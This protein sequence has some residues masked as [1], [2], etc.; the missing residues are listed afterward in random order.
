MVNELTTLRESML[1]CSAAWNF[2][3][4][5]EREMARLS[6]GDGPPNIQSRGAKVRSQSEGLPVVRYVQSNAAAA[7]GYLWASFLIAASGAETLVS[8]LRTTRR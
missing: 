8:R 3:I 7:F 4:E 1:R 2:D 6:G 5:M